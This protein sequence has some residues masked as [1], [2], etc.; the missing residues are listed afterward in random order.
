ML[1]DPAMELLCL[2]AVPGAGG[3]RARELLAAGTDEAVVLAL[4]TGHGLW[5]LLDRLLAQEGL[6][7]SDRHA[8]TLARMVAHVRAETGRQEAERRRVTGL[9]AAEGI[10][11]L[12]WKGAPLS[13]R[14]YGR[15]D[16]RPSQDIDLLV[17]P[18]SLQRARLCLEADGYVWRNAVPP[19][20]AAAYAAQ[21]WEIILHHPARG[22]RLDL[23]AAVAPRHYA[24]DMDLRTLW[25][26]ARPVP[27]P[28]GGAAWMPGD[29]WLG[30]LLAAHGTKHA[31]ERLLWVADLAALLDGMGAVEREAAV[32]VA[33][34]HGLRRVWE[35]AGCLA[36]DLAGAAP[37]GTEDPV[38]RRL[39]DTVWVTMARRPREPAGWRAALRLHLASR[40]RRSDRARYLAR[41]ALSPSYRDWL[42][43][44]GLPWPEAAARVL[45]PFRLLV[46]PLAARRRR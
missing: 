23:A 6:A 15:P 20:V 27:M 12:A 37:G 36:A 26:E 25:E 32:R 28:D 29:S 45:R 43:A 16:L 44:A 17:R 13:Q 33:A 14:L 34:V 3:G 5:M 41:L 46:L 10:R 24:L 4:A 38:V 40:E 30:L 9:L 11:P 21:G 1:A 2:A 35:L 22:A 19:S 18:E 31:W 7:L 39:A 42:L 8:A